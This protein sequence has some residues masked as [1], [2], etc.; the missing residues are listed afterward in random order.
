IVRGAQVSLHDLLGDGS[1]W[2]IRRVGAD[3]NAVRA[4]TARH[5]LVAVLLE[6]VVLLDI[7]KEGDKSGVVID[8]VR[9]ALVAHLGAVV[10]RVVPARVEIPTRVNQCGRQATIR[11]VEVVKSYAHLLEIVAAG[12]AGGGRT[13][14][15]DRGK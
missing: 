12:H 3:R 5:Q 10:R 7:R 9:L 2:V 6:Q 15:L 13:D 11:V 14:L 1:I 8:L 4:R